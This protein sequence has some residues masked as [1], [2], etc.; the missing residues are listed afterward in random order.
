MT[1]VFLSHWSEDGANANW[2]ADELR[3]RLPSIDVFSTSVPANRF[4]DSDPPAGTMWE[5]FYKAH[6]ESLR[7]FLSEHLEQAG[8]Y[9]LLLT[10]SS[11]RR[12][13]VWVR[14]EI[15]HATE[16]AKERNIPFI[17]CLLAVGYEAL[18]LDTRDRVSGWQKVE[19]GEDD[20]G[21][22]REREFQAIDLS[23]TGGLTLLTK[24]LETCSLGKE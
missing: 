8:A 16:R 20:D 24:V 10:E 4:D 11:V 18:E 7:A 17:P 13:S 23:S 15:R 2:L 12:H 1:V 19:V 22:H 9:L 21:Q 6:A 3:Q 5:A 14:W